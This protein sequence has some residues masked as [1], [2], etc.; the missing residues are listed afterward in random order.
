MQSRLLLQQQG[1]VP[2]IER[3]NGKF[4]K[5]LIIAG[6]LTAVLLIPLTILGAHL[7]TQSQENRLIN[8]LIKTEISEIENS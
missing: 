8:N 5:T 3:T 7:V 6:L 2:S 4:P 1:F